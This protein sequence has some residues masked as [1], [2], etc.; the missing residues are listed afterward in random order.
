MAPFAA[1]PGSTPKPI[2]PPILSEIQPI[3]E[4]M[5]RADSFGMQPL[6][7]P[8]AGTPSGAPRQASQL[9]TQAGAAHAF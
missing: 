6:S 4:S 1:P 2:K 8:L 5:S 9:S 3:D 7:P